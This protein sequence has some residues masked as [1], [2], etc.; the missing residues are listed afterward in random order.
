MTEAFKRREEI[1]SFRKFPFDLINCLHCGNNIS[2][3]LEN[4][5]KWLYYLDAEKFYKKRK[6]YAPTSS[7]HFIQKYS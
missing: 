1:F 7:I 5:Q 2:Q 6:T 3:I 4:F